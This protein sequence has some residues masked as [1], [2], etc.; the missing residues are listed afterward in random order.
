VRRS[1]VPLE[2]SHNAHPDGIVATD[3]DHNKITPDG[4]AAC[5]NAVVAT[6]VVFVPYDAV[7]AVGVPV[8]AGLFKSAL[9]EIAEAIAVNS[10][11]ISAPLTIFPEL[12]VGKLSLAVKFVALT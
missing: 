7:G 6:C 5:T 10:V 3:P 12:P 8:R 2:P 9:E 4:I 1:G 11:S